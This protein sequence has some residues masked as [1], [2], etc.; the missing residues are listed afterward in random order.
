MIDEGPATHS[1]EHCDEAVDGAS[2]GILAVPV[3]SCSVELCEIGGRSKPQ[4]EHFAA[5]GFFF[6]AHAPAQCTFYFI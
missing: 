2:R 6:S 5:E 3:A 1:I 4:H